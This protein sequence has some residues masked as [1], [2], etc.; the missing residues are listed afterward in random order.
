MI[1]GILIFAAFL[2]ISL[3]S[4][5]PLIIAMAVSLI[6]L[7]TKV[8]RLETEEKDGGNDYKAEILLL[9]E[10]VSR[11]EKGIAKEP[12][13]KPTEIEEPAQLKVKTDGKLTFE[14]PPE[15]P[16]AEEETAPPEP[17]PK[18]EQ[19][20]EPEEI[21][22]EEKTEPEEAPVEEPPVEELIEELPEP[23][24]LW[25]KIQQRFI[26]NWTGILGSI[27]MVMGIGFLGIYTALK[28]D[29]P[30]RFGMTVLFSMLLF[31]IFFYLKSKAKWVRFAL[32]LRSSAGAIFLFACLGSSTME[33]MKWLDHPLEGTGLIL[34]FLGIG[35]NL[36]LA[37]AGGHQVFASLHVLLSLVALAI[38]PPNHITFIVAAVVTLFGVAL[39]YRERWEY[40]LLLTITL[41]FAYH[42]YWYYTAAPAETSRTQHLAAIICVALV[43]VLTLLVH[44]RALYRTTEFERL[45]FFV[46]FMN[47][48]Y[49]GIGLYIHS[50]GSPWKPAIIAAGSM[51]AF[52]LARK[53]RKIGIRWLYVT[54]TLAAQA[55]MLFALFSIYQWKVAPFFIA[56]MMFLEVLLFLVVMI[57]E[58][59]RFLA[60][61]GSLL[62]YIFGAALVAYAFWDLWSAGTPLLNVH[63][64]TLLICLVFATAFH[65][66]L[67]KKFGGTG[68]SL[69]ETGETPW[70]P[71]AVYFINGF[72]ALSALYFAAVDLMWKTPVIALL[73]I[74]G[75]LIAK[76]AKTTGIHNLYVTGTLV[77]QV[78][79]SL[80]I[81]SLTRLGVYNGYITGL[82]FFE[83]LFF[84]LLTIKE[85][86]DFLR[87]IG[88]FIKY[89]TGIILLSRA[90]SAIGKH[91]VPDT[92]KDLI[93]IALC[94]L[95]ASEFHLYLLDKFGKRFDSHA[96]I[97]DNKWLPF[98]LYF[99]HAFYAG[100]ASYLFFLNWWWKVPVIALL[101]IVIYTAARKAK[102]T[103][104]RPLYVTGALVAQAAMLLAIAALSQ[105]NVDHCYILGFMFI[106]TLL[107]LVYTIKENEPPLWKTGTWGLFIIG[108]ILI[109]AGLGN[110]DYRDTETLFK[111]AGVFL[112]CA[113]AATLFHMYTL[114]KFGE[115]FAVFKTPA[116]S[117][118]GPPLN[119]HRVSWLG[120]LIGFLLLGVFI[121]TYQLR[122]WGYIPVAA[123]MVLIFIRHRF[124][125]NGL[126]FG[127]LIFVPLIH[128]FGW[129]YMSL[130][131]DIPVTEKL[132]FCLP[133]LILTFTGIRMPYLTWAKRSTKAIGI[134]L[135]Y[136]H[137]VI[138]SYYTFIH[139]SPFAAGVFWLLVSIV[140]LELTCRLRRKYGDELVEKGESDRFLLQAGYLLVAGFL[141]RHLAVHL[142]TPGTVGIFRLRSAVAIFAIF[143]FI[144][145]A[146]RRLPERENSGRVRGYLHPLFMELTIAFSIF[147]A[148][149]EID[150]RWFPLLW[151]VAGLAFLLSGR[152][153]EGETS[154]IRFYSLLLYWASTVY[155][156]LIP[157]TV[158]SGSIAVRWYNDPRIIDTGVIVLQFIYIILIHKLPFLEGVTF[159]R[160]LAFWGPFS[161]LVNRGKNAWIHYPL[162]AGMAI[163]LYQSFS[164]AILTLLWVVECFFIFISSVILKE[165]H[166]RYLA[167]TGLASALIRLVFYDMAKSD[168]LTRALVFI[169]VGVIMLVMNS[170]YNKYKDRF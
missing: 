122:W 150:S 156:A 50:F 166:F 161:D 48:F 105:W 65:L 107:F 114:K 68:E 93:T 134:Y 98:A 124:R 75:F 44:Y 167:M 9:Q 133:F 135:F 17:E 144:Y 164:R 30:Y 110:V 47:W 10:Q 46:H 23:N 69:D 169:G 81:I 80:A 146:V 117:R 38:A 113:A 72:Y 91:M 29:P 27:I 76:R 142:V 115:T 25:E 34:L 112:A 67:L 18:P 60:V 37:F 31:G 143:V 62:K 43:G 158:G 5:V 84:I 55:I 140:T 59:E 95:V 128:A 39:T 58:E 141:V 53:A 64:L 154:R 153:L 103:G 90:F 49:F 36:L 170:I 104:I 123:G 149:V 119:V 51:A 8:H 13:E 139:V 42:L 77:A 145:W 20:P 125:S 160:L 73:S 138:V 157:G 152:S 102:A 89:L 22:A 15:P 1:A 99:I 126:G 92:Y 24:P 16:A 82:L 155:V 101:S 35:V 54:D 129:N 14:T 130:T 41:F 11:L 136:A 57:V 148:A 163:F 19:E 78:T 85:K 28:V 2:S 131:K 108:V 88:T 52:F 97:E 147:T 6:I 61:M 159:P 12:E 100:F 66:Y 168:T 106:E 83:S 127:L 94:A 21:P 70:L 111:H 3:I 40:H 118:E 4:A 45:P 71:F 33:G 87:G 137:L 165:N 151:I 162:F 96:E 79:A 86:E 109:G 120:I 26:E 7:A 32:W 121:N 63:V 56:G 74:A 132:L 116:S